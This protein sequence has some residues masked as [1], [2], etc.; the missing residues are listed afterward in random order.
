MLEHVMDLHGL[1]LPA[2]TAAA[3]L[4]GWRAWGSRRVSRDFDW[5]RD[6][7]PEATTEQVDLPRSDAIPVSA[8]PVA[9]VDHRG[10]ITGTNRPDLFRIGYQASWYF[11]PESLPTFHRAVVQV[12]SY[13]PE[14]MIRVRDVMDEEHIARVWAE[15]NRCFIELRAV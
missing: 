15:R 5:W 2:A 4:A 13:G 10:A 11:E 8:F 12:L 14:T 3:W 9:S 6:V 7:D 1:L